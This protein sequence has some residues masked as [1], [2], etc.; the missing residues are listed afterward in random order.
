V[1]LVVA[2]VEVFAVFCEHVLS[3]GLWVD[4]GEG[5]AKN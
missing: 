1:V 5:N 4:C 3:S 2:D